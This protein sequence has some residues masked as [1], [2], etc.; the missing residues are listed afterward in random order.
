MA[1]TFTLAPFGMAFTRNL[2]SN[3][4]TF[5]ASLH[6]I[7]AAYATQIAYGDLV[8]T[9]GANPGYI[10]LAVAG[11]NRCLG[12]FAGC[13]PYY[14]PNVQQTIYTQW[15]NA[16]A[17]SSAGDID[18]WVIDD[19]FATFRIQ[20]SGTFA[21]SWIGRNA[22]WTAGTIGVP[23]ASGI[24]TMSLDGASVA[25]TATLPLRILGVCL[26]PGESINSLDVNPTVEVRL[27]TS[28][29]LTAL[30]T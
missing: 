8:E 19:P 5:Q 20:A 12:V 11:D 4:P 26:Q 2:V 1:Q 16:G 7:K 23:N 14:D 15:W 21:Q 17:P 9:D 28:E 22:P 13:Q 30:A 27:N 29:I 6:K 18:C 3:S 10:K 25:V 24:S